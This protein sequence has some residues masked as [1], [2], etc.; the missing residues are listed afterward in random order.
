MRATK[1]GGYWLGIPTLNALNPQAVANLETMMTAIEST[2]DQVRI[3]KYF[4]IDLR[5]NSGGN[6]FVALRVLNAIWGERTVASVRPHNLRA[7]WRAS[8]EN[9]EYLQNVVPVLERLFGPISLPANGLEQILGGFKAA[10]DHDQ[11]LY[12][13]SDEYAILDTQLAGPKNEVTAQPFLLTDGA[14]VSSC[15]NL[16]DLML[17]L[18]NVIHVGDETG[19]DTYYLENRPAQLPTGNAVLQIPIKLYSNR[20][21][22]KNAS[23]MPPLKWTGQMNDTDGL[24]SWISGIVITI[25]PKVTEP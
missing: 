2:A 5:G 9:R 1:G 15:L 14:C 10:I 3:A 21:R 4:V 8:H 7:Q 23:H 20:A 18:P 19:A 12:V 17:S 22:Q 24:E 16:V 11:P 13:D 25:R 6:T